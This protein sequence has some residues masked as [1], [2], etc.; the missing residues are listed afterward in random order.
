MA[1]ELTMPQMGYDMQEGTIVRW[2]KDEG[3]SVQMG[4]AIAEIETDKAI[5]EFESYADGTLR[6]ILISEGSTVPVGRTI[7]VV[8]EEDEELSGYA[9][10]ISQ[11]D[12]PQADAAPE[13]DMPPAASPEPEAV[14]TT[15]AQVPVPETTLSAGAGRSRASPLARRLA[16]ERGIDI[17]QVAGTGPG[18][19][20]VKDDVLAFAAV[21]ED[22]VPE[23]MAEETVYEEPVAE[24]DEPEA[25][26]VVVV[27]PVAEIEEPEAEAVVVVEEPVAEAE[28]PEP[29]AVVVVEEPVAEVDEPEAE[30]VVVVEE[31]VAEVDEPEA[32][33]VVVVEPV[34]EIE[35]PEAEVVVVVEEPVAEV[36]EPE[37][38]TAV[39]VEEPVAEIEEPEAEAVVVVVEPVAEVDEP[40]AET[41]VVVEEPV[42][43][44]D[45][46]EAETVVVVEEPVAEVDEPEAE[47]VVVVVEPVAEVDEPEAET[48][49]VVEPVAEIEEPEAE[50]DLVEPVAEIEEPEAELDLVEPVAEIDEPEA[51]A[52]VVVEE[53]TIPEPDL[54][55]M[56]IEE[57]EAAAAEAA[58]HEEPREAEP[59]IPEPDLE[60]VRTAPASAPDASGTGELV[61]LSRMRQQIARVT[62]RS[63]Q[64]QPHFYITSDIDMTDAMRL[65]RQ[66][67]QS[68]ESQGV[69]I[70]VNDLIV[71][72]C[73]GAIRRYPKFNSFFTADGI[74]MNERINIGIAIAEESGLIVPAILDCGGKSLREISSAAK[75]L[76]ARSQSGTLRSE[77]YTGSTFSTSNLGMFDV[78]SFTAII[79]PPQTGVLAAGSVEKRPVVQGNDI[80]IREMMTATL[81]ADHRVV[82]GAEGAQFMME[83][84][85]LLETPLSLLV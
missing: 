85:S 44:V 70:S 81:S 59:S 17:N 13:E 71:T 11:V 32:E 45:E 8:A 69:R 68:L 46:P 16:E 75:D 49:V 29:E 40:E 82:D 57:I 2:L 21:A 22:Q 84:K 30:A 38:E 72:A 80:V 65:R 73:V 77:E 26:A 27:E 37:A 15:A 58:F 64:E 51:E 9:S 47:T 3:A 14:A 66:I 28:E 39:V 41:V 55:P 43:E 56:V 24:V 4:E 7:A 52:V 79:H 67:N 48:A 61:P 35:E 19:R 25:E 78:T 23:A 60:P 83:V 62:V 50:L 5:V 42:A 20:V 53:P 1:T 12:E 74:Q 36:D 18:G 54:E 10:A 6:M 31:P 63:K 33:A 76:I 34:A